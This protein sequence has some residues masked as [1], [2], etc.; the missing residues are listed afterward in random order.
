MPRSPPRPPP[1]EGGGRGG[2]LRGT[3]ALAEGAHGG[4]LRGTSTSAEG[5]CCLLPTFQVLLTPVTV[6]SYN[7][8]LNG[9]RARLDGH[10]VRSPNR[11]A[12]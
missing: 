4:V 10:R 9:Y 1:C 12:A 11:F 2:G 3:S 6:R 7:R 8:P 5:A